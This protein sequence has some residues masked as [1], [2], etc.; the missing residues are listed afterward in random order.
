MTWR[1][2][3]STVIVLYSA[4][5]FQLLTMATVGALKPDGILVHCAGGEASVQGSISAVKP[6]DFLYARINSM[7]SCANCRAW[8]ISLDFGVSFMAEVNA[9]I[10]PVANSA[11]ITMKATSS[12]SVTPD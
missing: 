12:T 9:A 7:R 5:P 2:V 6:F 4:L 8:V 1:P 3:T 10:R 11:A